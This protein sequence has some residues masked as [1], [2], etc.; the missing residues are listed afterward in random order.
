[1][2]SLAGTIRGNSV[3]LN[4]PPGIPDGQPV[5]VQLTVVADSKTSARWPQ[6]GALSA[7]WSEEDDRILE[8][9]QE[10]RKTAGREL[11]E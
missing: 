8:S 5:I 9:I 2:K 3:Q 10:E 1:M 7:E 4:E 11:P 6:G